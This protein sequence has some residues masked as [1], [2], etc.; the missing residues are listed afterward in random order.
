M[1]YLVGS[2]LIVLGVGQILLRGRIARANAAS[3]TVVRPGMRADTALHVPALSPAAPAPGPVRSTRSR[4]KKDTAGLFSLMGGAGYTPGTPQAHEASLWPVPRPVI[5]AA[6]SRR[7]PRRDY[8]DWSGKRANSASELVLYA[9]RDSIQW[10]ANWCGGRYARQPTGVHYIAFSTICD[11][12]CIPPVANTHGAAI[13][14]GRACETGPASFAWLMDSSAC[15]AIS[16]DLCKSAM[17]VYQRGLPTTS[18]T[19]AAPVSC[20]SS[21]KSV[22]TN[23]ASATT[24][25]FAPR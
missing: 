19:S 13:V 22:T 9:C 14:V 20:S 24:F 18:F 11:D 8:S 16:M 3:N 2:V 12:L 7:T 15:D 21:C 5:A 25:R 10:M 4:Y 23:G 1:N 17:D 6:D